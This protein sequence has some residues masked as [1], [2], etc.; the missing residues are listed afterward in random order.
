LTSSMEVTMAADRSSASVG[1]NVSYSYKV[2]NTGEV[3][4]SSLILTD[5]ELGGIVLSSTTLAPEATLTAKA[6]RTIMASDL[7]GPLLS[8]ATVTGQNPSAQAVTA[9]SAEVSV[10][11]N[12]LASSVEV[13]VSSDRA[14]AS[15]GDNVTYTYAVVNTGQSNLTGIVLTDSKLGAITLSVNSLASQASLTAA[16]IHT[17]VATDLPGPLVTSATVMATG[18]SGQAVTVNSAAVS[19]RLTTSGGD[20]EDGSRETKGEIHKDRG[21]PGKGID[22]APGQQKY[23]NDNWGGDDHGKNSSGISDNSSK[24]NDNGKGNSGGKGNGSGRGNSSQRGNQGHNNN[25]EED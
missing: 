11:L 21:V 13:S 22:H 12:P 6:V 25:G 4:L 23:F 7:P 24:N 2:V 5:S 9:T 19:V 10:A 3:A 18:G 14:S 17:V 1:D 8:A 15:V 16:A 20:D